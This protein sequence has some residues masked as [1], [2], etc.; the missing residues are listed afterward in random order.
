MIPSPKGWKTKAKEALSPHELRLTP[1][2]TNP[3]FQCLEDKLIQEV[4][5]MVLWEHIIFGE[6]IWEK[7]DTLWM[8]S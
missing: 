6:K 3:V 4:F 1:L 5:H 8:T 2:D 7:G